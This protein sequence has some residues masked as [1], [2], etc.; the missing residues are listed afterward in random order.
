METAE[1]DADH[2]AIAER[3]QDAAADEF[4]A[5]ERSGHGVGERRAQ[6]DWEHDFEIALRHWISWI[7]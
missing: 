7:V 4:F 6:R 3:D 1:S 2:G 5:V